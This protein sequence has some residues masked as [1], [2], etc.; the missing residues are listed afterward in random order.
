MAFHSGRHT[1]PAAINL[2]GPWTHRLLHSR[3][4]R[5]H[6]AECGDP[7]DPL[8]L[9][10]HG[11]AGGWFDWQQV[12][13][14]LVGRPLHVVAVDSRGC[15]GTDKPPQGYD[16]A[17]AASDVA[18]LIA[19]LGHRSGTV[20]AH[21][22]GIPAAAVAAL[23]EPGRVER[24]IALNPPHPRKLG[25]LWG[26][27]VAGW[28]PAVG[29]RVLE[30]GAVV[31]QMCRQWAG[32]GFVASKGFQE[33]VSIRQVAL[34]IDHAAYYQCVRRQT[35]RRAMVG[36]SAGQVLSANWEGWRSMAA[37]SPV[38]VHVVHGGV[39]PLVRSR[40]AQKVMW[41]AGPQDL[42]VIPRV[43][44]YAHLEAPDVLADIV[45]RAVGL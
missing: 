11:F 23:A 2:D 13:R 16:L 45:E 36:R 5:F 9:L 22:D 4:L 30:R 19:A 25:S 21:S 33:M 18:G 38:P 24:I 12:M 3:G 41:A 20:V 15:G 40:A 8:V 28:N 39:D 26:V 27:R 35:V 31:E 10:V 34:R 14:Q 32:P 44:H 29:Q 6:T 43:G 17:T 7:A 1:D 42:T 37:A